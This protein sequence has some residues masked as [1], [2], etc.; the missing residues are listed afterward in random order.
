MLVYSNPRL[1][2]LT[3]STQHP[4]HYRQ[5]M[6]TWPAGSIGIHK[7]LI[8]ST[9]AGQIS[10][11]DAKVVWFRP[12]LHSHRV[13]SRSVQRFG[14]EMCSFVMCHVSCVFLVTQ[15][16]PVNSDTALI[17]PGALKNI[18]EAT[19]RRTKPKEETSFNNLRCIGWEIIMEDDG[20]L[21]VQNPC[22]T[23]PL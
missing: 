5:W 9:I 14:W 17:C 16:K 15:R 20:Y 12:D 11:R 22:S 13:W 18:K 10:T 3:P 6:M 21:T 23:K 1:P 2:R 4:R 8:F 19:G 7:P